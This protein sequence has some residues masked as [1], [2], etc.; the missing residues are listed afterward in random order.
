LLA[1]GA[2]VAFYI[3]NG[4]AMVGVTHEQVIAYKV[5]NGAACHAALK[6]GD[7]LTAETMV[8]TKNISTDLFAEFNRNKRSDVLGII[9]TLGNTTIVFTGAMFSILPFLVLLFLHTALAPLRYCGV[10]AWR[11]SPRFLG[12]VIPVVN[13]ISVVTFF[14]FIFF[15]LVVDSVRNDSCL[16]TSGHWFTYTSTTLCCI[17]VLA[18]LAINELGYATNYVVWVAIQQMFAYLALKQTQTYFHTL[19]E[20]LDGIRYALFLFPLMCAVGGTIA[21]RQVKPPLVTAQEAARIEAEIADDIALEELESTAPRKVARSNVPAVAAHNVFASPPTLP[22]VITPPLPPSCAPAPAATAATLPPPPPP[23][24]PTAHTGAVHLPKVPPATTTAPSMSHPSS[25][26]E[27]IAAGKELKKATTIQKAK[28][29]GS[30]LEQIVAGKKLKKATKIERAK[31]PV[32]N[33]SLGS[34]LAQSMKVLGS[35]LNP[36]KGLA[37]ENDNIDDGDEWD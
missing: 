34:F 5:A 9:T 22:A 33:S 18:H 17:F 36:D 12:L 32:N 6:R 21:I 7:L 1:F 26:L 31:T 16:L 35:S 10:K 30:L 4:P 23:G 24:P 8:R 19:E 2:F 11:L 20:S 15:H 29:P 25:L 37:F 28:T 3:K 14:I 13:I 27:Q